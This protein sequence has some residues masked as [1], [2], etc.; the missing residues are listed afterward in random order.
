MAEDRPS[1]ATRPHWSRVLRALREARGVT[2]EGWAALLRVGVNTVGRW[3]TG[4]AVPH[5]LAEQE[6]IVVCRERGLC[7][8]Y[9]D[10]P[11]GGVTLTP[12][13]PY[14]ARLAGP[15]ASWATR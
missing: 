2:Q 4:A 14:G 10:G 12:E 7:R 15:T 6:L 1:V 5:A 9:A 8:A 11:L 13:R 3:E